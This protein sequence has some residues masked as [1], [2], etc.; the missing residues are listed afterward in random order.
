M[1][2]TA[3]DEHKAIADTMSVSELV[4]KKFFIPGYQRPYKWGEQ[5]VTD[6]LQDIYDFVSD[7]SATGFYCLQPVVV[8]NNGDEYE[9]IDGQ[10]RITTLRLIIKALNKIKSG[11]PVEDFEIKY[12]TRQ[13]DKFYENLGE[14]IDEKDETIDSYYMRR[15]Y[16]YILNWFGALAAD[17]EKRK[18]LSV[19]MFKQLNKDEKD[20]RL[21][22]ISSIFATGNNKVQ[23][24]WY[25]PD[26]NE[27][28]I[29]LFLRLNS[30]KIPLTPAELIRAVF[31]N[32]ANKL[33][34]EDPSQQMLPFRIATE[35]DQM[36]QKLRDDDFWW[37]ISNK[38]PGE[39]RVDYLFELLGLDHIALA[40]KLKSGS[41]VVE[42]WSEVRDHFD[43]LTAWYDDDE[44]YHMIGFIIKVNKN[45]VYKL[46]KDRE[47]KEENT[48]RN[49]WFNTKRSK[50]IIV[51]KTKMIAIIKKNSATIEELHYDQNS[52]QIKVVL[53][54]YNI[55]LSMLGHERFMFKYFDLGSQ[56]LEHIRPSAGS[57]LK[58]KENLEYWLK[59]TVDS[60]DYLC[61]LKPDANGI[62]PADFANEARKIQENINRGADLEADDLIS[63]MSNYFQELEESDGLE[64]ICLLNKLLNIGV[65]NNYFIS[66]ASIISS[67][68]GLY[69]PTGTR[70]VFNKSFKPNYQNPF[71][72]SKQDAA[73]YLQDIK[74][75]LEKFLNPKDN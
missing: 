51:A 53:F 46:G 58:T 8:K 44:L 4:G 45:D 27:D 26:K 50:F 9:L 34:A 41:T 12:K 25:Q 2:D 56:E 33:A 60:E 24:I 13:P 72:W 36:E 69:V 29:K 43:M 62:N 40:N 14:L 67:N 64:N 42:Q 1:S 35:W 73:A 19:K 38:A 18:K 74:C 75:T 71:V 6:L 15:A 39:V 68:R 63:K 10:Q 37:F 20:Q 65:S 70:K 3:K 28:S 49:I 7:K 30:G 61:S 59:V 16:I 31:I 55:I 66:K 21:E 54:S 32:A 52:R 17:D 48:L 22:V 11:S 23:V 47:S 5:Q 57:D